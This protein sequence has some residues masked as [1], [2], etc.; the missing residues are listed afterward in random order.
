MRR[1]IPGLIETIH[2]AKSEPPRWIGAPREKNS[3]GAAFNRQ[4]PVVF[5]LSPFERGI[6]F[7]E[8]LLSTDYV[9]HTL[10]GVRNR[11]MK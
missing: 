9:L 2:Y 3:F 10:L 8:H 1:M 4:D 7:T 11:A 6:T 5:L